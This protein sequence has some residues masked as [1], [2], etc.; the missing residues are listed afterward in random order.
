[1]RIPATSIECRK[2]DE[3]KEAG[4]STLHGA[5]TSIELSSSPVAPLPS[6]EADSEAEAPPPVGVA[7][8]PSMGADAVVVLVAAVAKSKSSGHTAATPSCTAVYTSVS[9]FEPTVDR[10]GESAVPCRSCNARVRASDDPSTAATHSIANQRDDASQADSPT[11]PSNEKTGHL[12]EGACVHVQS[13]AHSHQRRT[14]DTCA[15]A[16]CV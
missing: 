1:M 4:R 12:W 13:E 3:E 5:V 15:G 6:T 9:T 16:S 11:A 7:A 14:R 8:S 10:R 2:S